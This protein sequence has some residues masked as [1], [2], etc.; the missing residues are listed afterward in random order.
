MCMDGTHMKNA[1]IHLCVDGRYAI[2]HYPGIGRITAMLCHEWATH[3]Q[4]RRLDIIVNSQSANDVFHL[5]TH[6]A[7]AHVHIHPLHA[8]PF[9]LMEWWQMR[10]IMRHLA[11]DWIYAPYLLMPPRSRD[12]KRLLTVHDAIPLE[13]PG[14]S[15][16]R[17]AIL[18]QFVRSSMARADVV[19]TVSAYAAAQIRHHY[20]YQG[21]LNIIPNG[22]SDVFFHQPV[23]H[24][25]P[26][27][28]ITKPYVLCVSS[29]QPHKN[30]AG[31]LHAWATAYRL[32]YIPRESQLVIAGHVHHHRALPWFDASYADL[33]IIH[34]ANPDDVVLNQLYHHAHLFVFPSLAEGFGLPIVEAMA[35]GN[36]VLCHDYP[37]LRQLH[38]DHAQ[39]TDMR[40]ATHVALDIGRLWH[41]QHTRARLMQMARTHARTFRWAAVASA[42]IQYMQTAHTSA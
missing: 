42:Y 9:G 11:P 33:P 4:I 31:L 17:R 22:V 35:A 18:R 39:Y 41:D 13:L 6:S 37:A 5:P 21:V 10:G 36:V 1:S 20:A 3:P 24:S 38:G 40:H 28:G 14:I 23:A 16:L 15:R 27:L 34:L 2:N 32:G 26:A 30:I 19:T 25:L 12:A 7:Y 29:N 8:R